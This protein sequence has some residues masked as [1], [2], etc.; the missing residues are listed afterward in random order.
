[1]A[2][3]LAGIK[4]LVEAG[5]DIN[6]VVEE[7]LDGSHYFEILKKKKTSNFMQVKLTIPKILFFVY[8]Q[9]IIFI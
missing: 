8:H 5:A 7:P 6:A 3:D 9:L 4:K 2:G 1:M